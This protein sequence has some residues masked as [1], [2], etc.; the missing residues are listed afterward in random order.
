MARH[1]NLLIFGQN[2][3]TAHTITT[4]KQTTD[5]T[6]YTKNLNKNIA[7]K[8]KKSK[9]WH[10]IVNYNRNKT[11][12]VKNTHKQVNKFGLHKVFTRKCLQIKL[13][14]MQKF[15][16]GQTECSFQQRKIE[17]H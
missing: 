16:I 9:I 10:C 13:S 3:Q 15:Y 14:R 2:H 6:N 7:N 17:I 12:I 11:H 1:T 4:P 5:K 8:L